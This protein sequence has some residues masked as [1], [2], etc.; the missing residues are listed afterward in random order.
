MTD[1]EQMLAAALGLSDGDQRDKMRVGLLLQVINDV[2]KR[3][4]EKWVAMHGM[5]RH[6][7][8]PP[9]VSGE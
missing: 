6:G 4:A 9:K 8:P 7:D 2:A 1:E 3:H 5:Q